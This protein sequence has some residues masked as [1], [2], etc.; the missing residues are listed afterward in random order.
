M[1]NKAPYKVD[2]REARETRHQ[3]G[4]DLMPPIMGL[5]CLSANQDA[6]AAYGG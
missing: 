5:S 6:G 2:A 3:A 1:T 4:E